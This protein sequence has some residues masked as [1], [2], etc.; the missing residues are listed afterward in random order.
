MNKVINEIYKEYCEVEGKENI[1]FTLA[2]KADELLRQLDYY[3][4]NIWASEGKI[5]FEYKQLNRTLLISVADK[6]VSGC[7]T[8]GKHTL[9]EYMYLTVDSTNTVLDR[10]WE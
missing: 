4:N 1:S 10:F 7:K 3:P 8:E 5:V 6:I 2:I 9:E